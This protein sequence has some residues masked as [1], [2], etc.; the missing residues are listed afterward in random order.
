MSNITKDTL[1]R[2]DIPLNERL[3]AEEPIIAG[4]KVRPYNQTVKLKFSRLL[5]WTACEDETDRNE[6]ILFGFIYLIAAP[7]ERVSLN[8]LNR[9]AYLLDK[10]AFLADLKDDDLKA[11]AD[12]FVTVT[13]LERETAVEVLPKPSSAP[14]ETAPPNS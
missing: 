11:G 7:I 10:D 5:R 6:E 1:Y 13:G 14:S 12:W 3:Y 9:S 2:A 4:V 8:T